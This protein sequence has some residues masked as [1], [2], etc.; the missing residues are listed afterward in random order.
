[1]AIT[2]TSQPLG[3]YISERERPRT[4]DARVFELLL[5][6]QV[7][8]SQRAGVFRWRWAHTDAQRAADAKSGITNEHRTRHTIEKHSFILLQVLRELRARGE[9]L[10]SVEGQQIPIRGKISR[11]RTYLPELLA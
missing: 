9:K 7:E 5:P 6:Y 3:A 4:G 1:M 2:D 11:E 8:G 10:Y